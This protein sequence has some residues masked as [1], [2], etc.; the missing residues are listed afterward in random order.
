MPQSPVFA[1]ARDTLEAAHLVAEAK[2]ASLSVNEFLKAA[3]GMGFSRAV[4]YK[5]LAIAEASPVLEPVVD[6]LPPSYH[7]L[8]ALKRV[9]PDTL[10]RWVKE[11]RVT[12]ASPL[13]AVNAL[14]SLETAAPAVSSRLSTLNGSRELG[15]LL[16]CSPSINHRPFLKELGLLLEKHRGIEFVPA[17]GL[18]A[19][20]ITQ[21]EMEK[22]REEA[23]MLLA[24]LEDAPELSHL[25]VLFLNYVDTDDRSQRY[26]NKIRLAKALRD[27]DEE[28]A[29]VFREEFPTACSFL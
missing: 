29:S 19:R 17:G 11:E 10:K 24:N 9:A 7:C 4:A 6:H 25:L 12:P 26:R 22:E 1:S 3:A 13:K 20:S 27:A 2:E 16:C 23:S 21:E 14:V 15:T 28:V 5:L 8:S 18:T